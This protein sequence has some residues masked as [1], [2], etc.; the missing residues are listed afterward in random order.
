MTIFAGNAGALAAECRWVI[1][2]ACTLQQRAG[3]IGDHPD[4]WYPVAGGVDSLP[5]LPPGLPTD[6]SLATGE[7]RTLRLPAF[8]QFRTVY[9]HPA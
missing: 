7:P 5:G 9:L 6:G 3:I 2:C 8:L 1:A 4:R